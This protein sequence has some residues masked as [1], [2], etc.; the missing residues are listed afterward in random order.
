MVKSLPANPSLEYLKNEA[1][2]VLKAHKKGKVSCCDVLRNLHQFKEKSD[3]EIF[4]SQ[5]SLQE[6]QFALAMEYGFKNWDGVKSH[7]QSLESRIKIPPPIKEPG[8]TYARGMSATLS[9]LGNDI[10][11][12]NVMGLTGVAFILQ[13]DTSGPFN[14]E[15][16]DC[17]WWPNDAWGFDLGLPILSK[18]TGTQNAGR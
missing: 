6:V 3:Q 9:Y 14:D 16:L 10:S 11:Y 17:A 5:T 15:G 4:E 13:I 8:N 2:S 18:A 1:K 12:E 7:I